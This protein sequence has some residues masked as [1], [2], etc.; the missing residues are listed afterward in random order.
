MKHSE[1]RFPTFREKFIELRGDRSNTEF[2]DFL[3]ISRQ[4]VGFY[5]NGERIPDILVLRQI[6][7][8]CSVSADWL[9]GLSEVKSVNADVKMVCDYTGL[10]QESVERL[11]RMSKDFIETAAPLIDE[12]MKVP[13]LHYRD[14]T[15]R[16]ALARIQ[17]DKAV[18]SNP[19]GHAG[20][21]RQELDE[22]LIENATI[23]DLENVNF[24]TEV[25]AIE[26]AIFYR[27][28]ALSHIQSAVEISI[29]NVKCAIETKDIK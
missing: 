24:L 9:I 15:F 11:H 27:D 7:E 19:L 10:T 17:S 2:A 8:K 1:Y 13:I 3:G 14:Y 28:R 29:N 25:P 5:I 18:K 16:A 22:R 20:K 12:I 21:I 6:A 23:K 4:T 26:A